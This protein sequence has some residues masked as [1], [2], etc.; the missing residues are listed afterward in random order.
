MLTDRLTGYLT[1]DQFQQLMEKIN[2]G[3]SSQELRF[4]ISEADENENGVIDFD[5][6]VPVAADLIQSFR[7]RAKAKAM[8]LEADITVDDQVLST[9]A[10]DEIKSIAATCLVKIQDM[11]TRKYGVIRPTELRRCLAASTLNELEVNMLCQLLPRDNFGRCNYENFEDAMIHVRFLSLKN[12]ALES[13]GSE[14]QRYLL[15]ACKEEETKISNIKGQ[16]VEG[17]TASTPRRSTTPGIAAT[18]RRGATP[19]SLAIDY[20]GA[21]GVLP[22]RSLINI[23]YNAPRLTLTRLQVLVIMAEAVVLDGMINYYQFIPLVAKTIEIMFEPKALRQRAELIEKT[24]YTTE[25][26]LEGIHQDGFRHKLLTLFKC[27][28]IDHNNLLDENEFMACLAALD[29]QLTRG[30]IL[31]LM[32]ASAVS[33]PGTLQFDEFATFFSN[34]LMTLEKEKHTRILQSKIHLNFR[35]AFDMLTSPKSTLQL[36]F[37]LSPTRNAKHD[38]SDKPGPS[39]K[40]D[41]MFHQISGATHSK[42]SLPSAVIK[43]TITNKAQSSSLNSNSAFIGDYDNNLTAEGLIPH[44]AAIFH[45]ADKEGCGYLSVSDIS[46]ILRGLDVRISEFELDLL[47]DGVE[48]NELGDVDYKSFTPICAE[49]LET[50]RAY[51]IVTETRLEKERWAAKKAEK[52]VANAYNEIQASARYIKDKFHLVQDTV[53]DNTSRQASLEELFLHVNSGLDRQEVPLVMAK[54]FVSPNSISSPVASRARFGSFITSTP[55]HQ[56]QQQQQNSLVRKGS[57]STM[58]TVVAAKRISRQFSSTIT[59]SPLATPTAAIGMMSAQA[60]LNNSNG[61]SGPSNN[62]RLFEQQILRPEISIAELVDILMDARKTT[63]IRGLAD[64]LHPNEMKHKLLKHLAKESKQLKHDGLLEEDSP[65]LPLKTCLNVVETLQIVRIHRAKV[66]AIISWANCYDTTGTMLDYVKFALHTADVLSRLHDSHFMELFYNQ[67]SIVQDNGIDLSDKKLLS[68]GQV[69]IPDSKL[70]NGMKDVEVTTYLTASCAKLDNGNQQILQEDFIQVLRHIPRLHLNEHD[71]LAVLANIPANMIINP[72]TSSLPSS[73]ET[74][75]GIRRGSMMIPSARRVSVMK[76]PTPGSIGSLPLPSTKAANKNM[77]NRKSSISAQIAATAAAVAA[78][79][80]LLSENTLIKWKEFI[81]TAHDILRVVLHERQM[82]RLRMLRSTSSFLVMTDTNTDTA[83]S[84]MFNRP[85]SMGDSSQIKEEI[86]ALKVLSKRFIDI[87]SIKVIDRSISIVLPSD[88]IMRQSSMLSMNK[89]AGSVVCSKN[90][91]AITDEDVTEVVKIS[92]IL[93]MLSSTFVERESSSPAFYHLVKTCS[94]TMP[95]LPVLM[96]IMAVERSSSEDEN[97]E[98]Y[99]E[100]D[101]NLGSRSSGAPSLVKDDADSKE[102]LINV[103]SVDGR[104]A[105]S[106]RLPV[107]I[108]AI[109]QVD[110]ELALEFAKNLAEKLFIEYRAE[111]SFHMQSQREALDPACYELKVNERQ[112]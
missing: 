108:P 28:D 71:A 96:R 30:E 56:Q 18:P 69:H 89:Q 26:L 110:K 52:M 10:K 37:T 63:I 39:F 83:M 78:T 20:G 112:I 73:N 51:A 74:I 87:I 6:F 77:N 31:S 55:S 79:K 57:H 34:N 49:L 58:P 1:F 17:N 38:E 80:T 8:L 36:P 15:E 46:E 14:L 86:G 42:N 93:P 48:K 106:V 84:E 101:A 29:L 88:G 12:A 103:I 90:G 61:E 40:T 82:Q 47:L 4:V 76:S 62:T 43:N 75:I 72:D 11:D 24:S 19:Q 3:I 16:P 5:E 33:S 95:R 111:Q 92:A 99:D 102:I 98:A 60:M 54:L 91:L 21:S 7:A 23:L 59:P 45:I 65:Y 107:Q 41:L 81:P 64:D 25:A 66:I 2:L 53:M 22:V 50:F 100:D 70:F 97:V 13:Y 67:P 44:L 109:V 104:Y 68:K 105:G 35:V 94:S 32:N 85:L 9:L 27:Y